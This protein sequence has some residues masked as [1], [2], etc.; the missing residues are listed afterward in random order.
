MWKRKSFVR[1]VSALAY[2]STSLGSCRVKVLKFGTAA[3]GRDLI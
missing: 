3:A 2:F 1:P